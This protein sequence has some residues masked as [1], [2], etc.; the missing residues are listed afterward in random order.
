M[1]VAGAATQV[2]ITPNPTIRATSSSTNTAATVQ[3]E[4]MFDHA[5]HT[6]GV[7]LKLTNSD[8]GYLDTALN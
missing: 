4:D 7:T 1:L 8:A 5:V 3:L 6:F 2:L